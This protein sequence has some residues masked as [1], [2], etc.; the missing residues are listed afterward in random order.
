MRNSV[1]NKFMF[2]TCIIS[3]YV[4]FYSSS[5]AA[6]AIIWSQLGDLNL[7]IASLRFAVPLLGLALTMVSIAIMAGVIRPSPGWRGIDDRVP[8]VV[9]MKWAEKIW[10]KVSR[11]CAKSAGWGSFESMG[12]EFG[13]YSLVNEI[14]VH[15]LQ[16]V[17]QYLCFA[18]FP[19]TRMV[20][21]WLALE[22]HGRRFLEPPPW[23]HTQL[24]DNP[25]K[26]AEELEFTL[27][28]IVVGKE[29]RV[30]VFLCKGSFPRST[31]RHQ[32]FLLRCGNR[33]GLFNRVKVLKDYQSC[34]SERMR[35]PC[36]AQLCRS[37]PEG[38]SP[39]NF[40]KGSLRCGSGPQFGYWK[41]LLRRMD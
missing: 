13:N 11:S 3:N 5:T 19:I 32:W 10:K 17:P 14:G 34:W 18:T 7:T 15:H 12:N 33:R 36:I 35:T 27:G 4:A 21:G 39:S 29:E 38:S 2:H 37:I 1:Y 9:V 16:S 23:G 24:G 31:V 20:C 26:P 6:V 41:I 22:W 8:V 28:T 40:G 30:E 25:N